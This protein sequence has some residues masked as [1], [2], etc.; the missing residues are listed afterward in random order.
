VLVGLARSLAFLEVHHSRQCFDH[1][2]SNYNM[3]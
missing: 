3:T 2:H 1:I